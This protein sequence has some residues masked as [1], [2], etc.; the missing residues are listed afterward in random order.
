MRDKEQKRVGLYILLINIILI[1]FI[2][3][4]NEFDKL[5][6]IIAAI[7]SIVAVIYNYH[8]MKLYKNIFNLVTL[9]LNILIT[10]GIIIYSIIYIFK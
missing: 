6:L 5:Y 2:L 4:T 10:N 3:T 7:S 9:L 8:F 1:L